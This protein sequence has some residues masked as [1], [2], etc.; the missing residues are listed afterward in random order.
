MNLQML[1]SHIADVRDRGSPRPAGR[2]LGGAPRP[3]RLRF[4][5]GSTDRPPVLNPPVTPST[6]VDPEP[7]DDHDPID[8]HDTDLADR[9]RMVLS[10]GSFPLRS[11][12]VTVTGGRVLLSGRVVSYYLKQVAQET[13]R[14]VSGISSFENRLVVDEL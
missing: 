4:C 11:V 7:D 1:V 6:P 9:V 8:T 10:R 2:T 12:C 13:A 3:H 5:R 14:R